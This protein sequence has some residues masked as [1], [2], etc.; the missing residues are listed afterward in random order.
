MSPAPRL[1]ILGDGR[2]GRAIEDLAAAHGF[3]M[4]AVFGRE[5]VTG[6]ERRVTAALATSDV[7]VEVSVPAAAVENVHLCLEAGCAVVVGTTGWYDRLPEVEA[8][9][10]E[11]AGSLLWAAN[12]SLGV[13]L[14]RALCERAGALVARAGGFDA[15]LV[16]THHAH[17]RDAPSGTAEVLARA[18]EAEL[19]A[20]VP[21]TSVRVGQVPGT[22]ELVI[23]GGYEQLVI[24]HVA[25]D[26][27]VFADGALHAATWLRG[28]S[29]VWTMNDVF[30]LEGR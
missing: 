12:F 19:G 7:A 9:V 4:E 21:I 3:E 5:V 13:T 2:M 25:R 8:R 23:D 1:V 6:D 14:M 26:R 11:T 20:E 10:N 17:K 28:R 22:H 29:G 24:R 30:E 27:K 18:T 15:S 16:E